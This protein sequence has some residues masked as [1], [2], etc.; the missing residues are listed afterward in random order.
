[1]SD[2]EQRGVSFEAPARTPFILSFGEEMSIR[3]RTQDERLQLILARDDFSSIAPLLDAARGTAL[4]TTAGRMLADYMILLEQNVPA[5]ESEAAGRLPQAVQ[6][7]VTA[8]IAPTARDAQA[9]GSQI[10]F[11]LME[12]VRRAV[13]RN[14]TSPSL[15]PDKLCREAGT[16]RS[17]L[18][19]LLEAQGGVA[20]YIRRRRLAESFSLLGN[21]GN[22]LTVGKIAE[23]LCF[24]DASSFSRA[25]RNEFGITP[26]DVRAATGAGVL[27]PVPSRKNP[28]DEAAHT[29][30][31]S[32]SAR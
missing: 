11:A 10:R 21:F 32:L 29:F 23:L 9:A 12:R 5:L 25:F 26:T 8:C 18:Y 13:V 3:R 30:T 27:P 4:T 15:G 1:M 28:R 6:A 31:N 14:L 19:R 17:Q 20:N 24:S 7:M 22:N 2:V 16:S